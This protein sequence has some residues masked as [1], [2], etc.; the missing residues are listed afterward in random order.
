[1]TEVENIFAVSIISSTLLL[2]MKSQG[3]ESCPNEGLKCA[4]NDSRSQVRWGINVASEGKNCE[5]SLDK[6]RGMDA[7]RKK[8]K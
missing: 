2:M 8:E 7:L 5:E 6:E 1:M 3:S 4:K